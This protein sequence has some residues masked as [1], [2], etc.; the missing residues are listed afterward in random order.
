M[1]TQPN[2]RHENVTPTCRRRKVKF[3]RLFVVPPVRDRHYNIMPRDVGLLRYCVPWVKIALVPDVHTCLG[4]VAQRAV[5]LRCRITSAWMCWV[6]VNNFLRRSP[7]FGAFSK[8]RFPTARV[9]GQRTTL[10]TATNDNGPTTKRVHV[11]RP[12]FRTDFDLDRFRVRPNP[13]IPVKIVHE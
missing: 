12:V 5:A 8:L 4:G 3:R 6:A 9:G 13:I 10:A 2:E 11:V 1:E 7:D